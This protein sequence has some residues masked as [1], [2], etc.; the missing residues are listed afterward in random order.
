MGKAEQIQVV[1]DFLHNEGYVPNIDKDGDIVFKYEGG[2]YL[3]VL[4]DDDQE[5]F[6]LI[7]PSFWTLESPAERAR[8]EHAALKVTAQTKVA[9]VYLTHDNTWA[10]VEL[11]YTSIEHVIPIFYRSMRALRS[12]VKSFA[13]EMAQPPQTEN[14]R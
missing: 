3:I 14:S 5:F 11:F 8:A 7:F 2:T 10:A 12:I 13:D 4:D 1:H 6:R 9:K